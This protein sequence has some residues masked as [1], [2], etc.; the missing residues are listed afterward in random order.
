FSSSSRA[1]SR[2]SFA[3]CSSSGRISTP[4]EPDRSGLTY[5]ACGCPEGTDSFFSSFAVGLIVLLS[6]ANPDRRHVQR[7]IGELQSRAGAVI[8]H[9]NNRRGRDS[10][11]I[12]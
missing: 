2:S 11:E 12:S 9:P 5:P 1:W 6:L 4:S 10:G 8:H 3:F 7:P